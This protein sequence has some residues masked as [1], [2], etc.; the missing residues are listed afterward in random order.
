M[1]LFQERYG[2]PIK[3]ICFITLHAMY[4]YHRKRTQRT[5][6]LLVLLLYTMGSAAT[7]PFGQTVALAPRFNNNKLLFK[8]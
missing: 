6:A 2:N 4:R 8:R 5:A 7:L 3:P 1:K